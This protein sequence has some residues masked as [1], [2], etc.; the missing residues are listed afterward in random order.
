V[1]CW[2]FVVVLL[3]FETFCDKSI[4]PLKSSEAVMIHWFP[5]I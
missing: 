1:V 2:R 4:W 3:V 5:F